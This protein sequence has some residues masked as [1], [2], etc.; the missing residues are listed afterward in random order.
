MISTQRVKLE[1]MKAFGRIARD[2]NSSQVPEIELINKKLLP[3]NL[4]FE[5]A[6]SGNKE[7]E[8]KAS[9]MQR[10]GL[11]L[12]Y[13]QILFDTTLINI[14]DI[15]KA[16]EFASNIPKPKRKLPQKENLKTPMQRSA[17]PMT[18]LEK[19]EAKHHKDKQ[20][21]EVHI[22]HVSWVFENYFKK[23][24]QNINK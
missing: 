6:D 9:I 21:V 24:I 15:V 12:F 8:G 7:D 19:M 10:K 11:F 14:I 2:I 3:L 16:K 1:K 5:L 20:K 17:N 18:E 23:L 13:I 22:S 4:L